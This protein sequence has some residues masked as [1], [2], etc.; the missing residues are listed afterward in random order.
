VEDLSYSLMGLFQINM[1][2]LYGEGEDAFQR[3]Q[4]AILSRFVDHT[5]FAWKEPN[6]SGQNEHGYV[7]KLESGLLASSPAA[8]TDSFDITN[9][10]RQSSSHPIALTS[11][12]ISLQMRLK[13]S[14]F[15]TF[16]GILDCQGHH[17]YDTHA[18]AALAIKLRG[19]FG[20]DLFYRTES[21]RT[22]L[23]E[24][25]D[26][27]GLELKD[28]Y[29]KRSFFS[30][31]IK[32]TFCAPYPKG[33]LRLS[34]LDVKGI[35]L[36]HIFPADFLSDDN[37]FDLTE[38][39]LETPVIATFELRD[40]DRKR[41]IV[42]LSFELSLVVDVICPLE[43]QSLEAVFHSISWKRSEPLA[44]KSDRVSWRCSEGLSWSILI[45]LRK[46]VISGVRT[47]VL[48]ISCVDD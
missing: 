5:I 30:W 13:P 34:G 11:R 23:V 21:D 28:I 45:A 14:G 40:A 3:L 47:Q 46:E 22:F 29:V 37:T 1:P 36:C 4:E 9:Y 6:S 12:G 32:T 26:L 16:L 35:T 2:L 19:P 25:K 44:T 17:M 8:F 48:D 18:L 43:N 27:E 31:K 38:P 7:S 10:G 41:F 39:P 42:M 20:G 24:T 33:L 15:H